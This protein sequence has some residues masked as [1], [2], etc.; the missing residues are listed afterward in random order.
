MSLMTVYHGSEMSANGVGLTYE[1]GQKRFCGGFPLVFGGSG[2]E[3]LVKRRTTSVGWRHRDSVLRLTIQR[4]SSGAP[5]WQT[6]GTSGDNSDVAD[7]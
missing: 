6:A 2:D 7:L 5:S 4:L 3:V 1:D